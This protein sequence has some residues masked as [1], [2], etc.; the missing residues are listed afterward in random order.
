MSTEIALTNTLALPFLSD[1][2]AENADAEIT[3]TTEEPTIYRIPEDNYA[4]LQ[5]RFN[6]L[7]RRAA[8]LESGEI[9]MTEVD[10]EAYPGFFVRGDTE[11]LDRLVFLKPD[12]DP[13][14]K[15]G[16]TGYRSARCSRRVYL[17]T[18]TGVSPRLNGWQF[19]GAIDVM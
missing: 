19:I 10:R 13:I 9:S 2:P 1:S 4:S 18:V 14:A 17:V 15:F 16:A 8:K 5:A 11:H 12:T 7:E 3:T 6:R